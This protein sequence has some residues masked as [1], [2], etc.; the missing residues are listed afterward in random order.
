M[1]LPGSSP[2]G[3]DAEFGCER[4]AVEAR[5]LAG[6]YEAFRPGYA[7]PKLD[8]IRCIATVEG[9]FTRQ[10]RPIVSVPHIFEAL[11]PLFETQPEAVL[12]GE[13]YHHDLRDGCHEIMRLVRCRDVDDARRAQS[14]PMV[15]YHFQDCPRLRPRPLAS[16]GRACASFSNRPQNGSS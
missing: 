2:L 3:P 7:Q 4:C 8:G 12:D 6:R 5:T 15:Q 10:G 13:L 11:K 14:A 16:G 1:G 9:L